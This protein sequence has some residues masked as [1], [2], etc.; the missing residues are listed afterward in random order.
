MAVRSDLSKTIRRIARFFYWFP[1]SLS[2]S[3][4]R[5]TVKLLWK[6]AGKPA[7]MFLKFLMLFLLKRNSKRKIIY[8]LS[9]G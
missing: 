2:S 5:R 8:S 7:A 1:K 3:R 9:A 4:R 6:S